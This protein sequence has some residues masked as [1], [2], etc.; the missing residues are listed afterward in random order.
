MI[1][2]LA[3]FLIAADPVALVKFATPEGAA[4][5]EK[6][7]AKADFF[8]LAGHFE[9]QVNGG[10]CGPASSV[11]VLN[12]LRV[13]GSKAQL[14]RDTSTVPPDVLSRLP[15]GVEVGLARYTQ[16]A[17]I[18]DPKF[19]S[20]KP[21][22][23]FYGKPKDAKSKPS[24]GLQLREL[25]GVLKAQGLSV[26][27]HVVDAAANEDAI[28]KEIAENVGRGGDFV[29]VNFLRSVVGQAG[30]GHHSP[31][32]AYD[33]ASKSFLLLDT[34]PTDGKGWAWIPAGALVAAMRTADAIENRGYLIVKEGA[35]Q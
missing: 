21:L 7:K 5:L 14:P 30:G 6:A 1:V 33:E 32:G 10:M 11:I 25:A 18:A 17:L 12:A 24:P 23:Q 9:A 16:T 2:A 34:N 15:K 20:V 19:A 3:L 22:D 35:P 27:V 29:I 8:A 26:D 13:D 4:R 28:V 31:V